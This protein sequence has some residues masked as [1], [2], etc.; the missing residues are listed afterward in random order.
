MPKTWS[1]FSIFLFSTEKN[2]GGCAG[3]AL[4]GG[5]ILLLTFIGLLKRKEP[6]K[7][8]LVVLGKLEQ[9]AIS[10]TRREL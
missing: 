3:W 8:K 4:A 9:C 5:Y 2:G 1:P 7:A 6:T 10:L